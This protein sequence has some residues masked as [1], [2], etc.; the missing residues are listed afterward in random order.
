[1]M[2]GISSF[3][4]TLN[5]A[6]FGPGRTVL[7]EPEFANLPADSMVTVKVGH[8]FP[9]KVPG[10]VDQILSLSTWLNITIEGRPLVRDAWLIALNPDPWADRRLPGGEM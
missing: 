1:M 8:T 4:A 6:D 10:A 9:S 3:I 7:K 2:P 5:L